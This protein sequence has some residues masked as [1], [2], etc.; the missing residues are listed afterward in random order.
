M[1]SIINE[2]SFA[3]AESPIKEFFKALFTQRRK[4]GV[5]RKKEKRF[6]CTEVPEISININLIKGRN[7]PVRESS[8]SII[9][10]FANKKKE[11]NYKLAFGGGGYGG[12]MYGSSIGYGGGGSMGHGMMNNPGFTQSNFQMQ[13]MQQAPGTGM[14]ANSMPNVS[15]FMREDNVRMITTAAQNSKLLYNNLCFFF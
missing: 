12:S 11:L 13:G 14:Y 5:V 15:R 1:R 2:F 3:Q 7:I 10:N 9:H 4:L 8:K 6:A